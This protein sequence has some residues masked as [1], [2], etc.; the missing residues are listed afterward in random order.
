MRW[1]G[2]IRRRSPWRRGGRQ[3]EEAVADQPHDFPARHVSLKYPKL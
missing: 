2:S 3:E 1:P